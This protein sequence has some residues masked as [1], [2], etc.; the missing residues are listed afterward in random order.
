MVL[1]EKYLKEL[2]IPYTQNT[3]DKFQNYYELLIEWNNKFNLTT[4][5]EKEEVIIKHFADSLYGY[6]YIKNATSVIDIGSGAG[7]PAIPLAIVLENVNFT[8][9]DSLNKRINFLNE[10]ISKLS[11]KNCKTYHS[12]AEDFAKNNRNKFDIAI[13]RAVA[14]LPTLLEYLVPLV[15]VRGKTVC[16]KALSADEEILNSNNAL[17]KLN[18]EIEICEKYNIKDT[19]FSRSLVVCTVKGLC[20]KKYPRDKNSPKNNPL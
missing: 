4:I 5:T 10:V 17:N 18:A 3:L 6:K 15:K 16:Y 12:R 2:E 14:S 13:A 8:L 11:L 7:F 20:D 19:D 1:L 9:V